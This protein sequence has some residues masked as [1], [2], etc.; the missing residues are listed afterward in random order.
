MSLNLKNFIL[1]EGIKSSHA[2]KL[3]DYQDNF[4]DDVQEDLIAAL[5]K[6]WKKSV[7]HRKNDK[8]DEERATE[9]SLKNPNAFLGIEFSTKEVSVGLGRF[10]KAKITSVSVR[11]SYA[12]NADTRRL[13]IRGFLNDAQHIFETIVHKNEDAF[14][15]KFESGKHKALF[16]VVRSDDSTVKIQFK[17]L[18]KNKDKNPKEIVKTIF[19]VGVEHGKEGSKT[20]NYDRVFFID[21]TRQ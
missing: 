16:H 15:I 2:V 7:E 3:I 13:L 14:S 21:Y 10:P 9:I 11:I 18:E 17:T 12:F 8:P 1:E 4:H 5:S 6:Q 20:K 19:M